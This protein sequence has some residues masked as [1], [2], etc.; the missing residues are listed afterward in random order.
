MVI[1]LPI[2]FGVIRLGKAFSQPKLAILSM[3]LPV[4][5]VF[6]GDYIHRG[7]AAKDK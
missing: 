7:K 1:G 2:A 6:A 4:A 3:F 5:G